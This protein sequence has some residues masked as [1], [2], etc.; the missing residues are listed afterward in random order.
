MYYDYELHLNLDLEGGSLTEKE[1]TFYVVSW[2]N[3]ASYA[4]RW[5]Y[6]CKFATRKEALDAAVKF[7]NSNPYKVRINCVSHRIETYFS[8][9]LEQLDEKFRTT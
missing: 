1:E 3:P 5:C 9:P 7:Q 6:W 2:F 4:N 8:K